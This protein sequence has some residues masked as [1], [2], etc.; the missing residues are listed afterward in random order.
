MHQRSDR[1]GPAVVRGKGGQHVGVGLGKAMSGRH[2][3][4]F[5][6]LYLRWPLSKGKKENTCVPLKNITSQ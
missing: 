2:L 6:T 5:G 3:I 4:K 1:L